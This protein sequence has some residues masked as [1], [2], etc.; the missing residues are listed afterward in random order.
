MMDRVWEQLGFHECWI[1]AAR[2]AGHHTNPDPKRQFHL[3]P[4][5]TC[6]AVD[7]RTHQFS[8]PQKR[9]ARRILASI[10]G[11]DYD[12]ILEAEGEAN[13]HIHVQYDPT[14]QGTVV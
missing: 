13:E 4:D 10:L 1:T 3:L 6:Q 12:V 8:T 5:G 9:E 11:K 14:R 7:G 2:E